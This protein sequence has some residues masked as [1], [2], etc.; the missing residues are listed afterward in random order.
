MTVFPSS[1]RV[2]T[3]RVT[4]ALLCGVVPV[5]ELPGAEPVV[6]P[7]V[8]LTS[9][10]AEDQDDLCV[11]VH[12]DE[13]TRSTV[14]AADK[15]ANKLFVYDLAGNV[16]QELAAD[17][18]GNIDIRNDFSLAGQPCSLVVVVIREGGPRLQAFRVDAASRMLTRVDAGI[19]TGPNYGGCLYQSRRDGRLYFIATSEDGE[20][21]Q[22][23][24]RDN[25]NGQVIGECVR[26]WPLGKCESAVADDATSSLYIGEESRGVWKLG[27]EP[28]D[29]VPGH[30][31]V[32]IGFHG[33]E[34]DIEGLALVPTGPDTGYLIV[35]DQ[36]PSR[37][38]VFR[39]EQAHDYVGSFRVKTAAE[40]DGIDAVPVPL[41]SQFSHGLF[42]CHSAA[43][44]P[45]PV[46]LISW[47]DVLSC[48]TPATR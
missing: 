1:F 4:V 35:S 36:G 29:P 43:E 42:A 9:P 11:W 3:C 7:V 10:S 27:A 19:S 37:F 22:Y 20:V 31:I 26:K 33:I 41:G 47:R 6:E 30:L 5:A 39:R 32:E 28:D 23:E 13:P 15:S 45:C 38:H 25:G 16:L 48:L 18:P 44:T 2:T 21:G 34:G 40:S 17:K 24:L 8:K 12:P 14:I 46:L